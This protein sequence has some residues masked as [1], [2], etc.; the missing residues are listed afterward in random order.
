MTKNQ[1]IK[2]RVQIDV[3]I[4]KAITDFLGYKPS[5]DEVLDKFYWVVWRGNNT[6]HLIHTETG[7]EL[8]VLEMP[9]YL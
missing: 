2:Y 6:K 4:E 1:L 7:K 8:L 5:Y 9:W 3:C